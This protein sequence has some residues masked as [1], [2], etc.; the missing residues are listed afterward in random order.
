VIGRR[1]G[2]LVVIGTAKPIADTR[3]NNLSRWLVECD[4]GKEKVVRQASLRNGQTKSCGCVR[5][6]KAVQ[7]LSNYR[8]TFNPDASAR[9][10]V[11]SSYRYDAKKRGQSWELTD[12]EFLTLIFSKCFYC[13]NP[14]SNRSQ[15][16]FKLG[17]GVCICNGIDRQDNLKGYVMNNV[18]PCC[19]ICNRM[20]GA[21]R[22]EEFINHIGRLYRIF[23]E[24][25][26]LV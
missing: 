22:L 19:K 13:G 4:C 12:D 7:R 1:F 9:N 23:N 6:E 2:K 16:Q 8:I 25:K 20:K 26:L 11:L 18:V 24:Q 14:P 15:R 3:G 17:L 5:K 10:D 21:M